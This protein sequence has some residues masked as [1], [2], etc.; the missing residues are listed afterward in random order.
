MQLRVCDSPLTRHVLR[1]P[2]SGVVFH[3]EI[4]V[5][6]AQIDDQRV[7]SRTE[8]TRYTLWPTR[9]GPA[10]SV[11]SMGS[12]RGQATIEWVGLVMLA[13]LLLGGAAALAGPNVDGRSFGGFLTYRILC[14]ARGSCDRGDSELARAYGPRDAELLRRHAPNLVFEPGEAQLPVDWGRCRRRRCADAP[15]DRNLDG[16]RTRAGG[17]AT[18][19]TRLLRRGGRAYLQYWFYYPDSN[20]TVAG[21]D[22]LW[23]RSGRARLAGLAARGT[24]SWPGFHLDDWEGY[25]VRVD[26][27]G[28]VSVRS[29]SHRHYQY[30]KQKR[31]HNRWGPETGWTRVSRGSHAG[32]IPLGDNDRRRIPG[33]D[34]RERTSTAEG[35]RLIPLEPTD[36]RRYRPLDKSVTPPWRKPVYR[37]P[38]DGES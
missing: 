8:R 28:G 26:R 13:A 38:E 4:D 11:A 35:L 6:K 2:A 10:R 36:K 24:T 27:R 30:C 21:L 22:K 14:T 18:L 20:T 19:Y 32:H 31:C 15:D 23:S 12:E 16:H 3:T 5:A 33:R 29:T 9:A 7:C 17:R 1:S 34:M 37:H 25:Q